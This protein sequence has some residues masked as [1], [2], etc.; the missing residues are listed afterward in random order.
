MSKV[1]II[2]DSEAAR[3]QMEILV[4]ELNHICLGA[5]NGREA[6]NL[7]SEQG[8]V[9]LI[10][11]DIFMPEM[12]GLETI[13][14]IAQTYPKIRVIAVSAGGV[15]MSGASMLEIASGMGARAVLNKPFGAEDFKNT[16][17]AVLNS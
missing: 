11:T 2:E 9:D 6:I 17:A 4:T 3:A 16:I 13:E 10:V 1:L 15:G 8:D 12:D 14:L 7:L 5:A